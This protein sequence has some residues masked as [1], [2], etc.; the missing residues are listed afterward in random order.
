MIR[1]R[2]RGYVTARGEC[3]LTRAGF[4]LSVKACEDRG[5]TELVKEEYAGIHRKVCN[6]NNRIPGNLGKY[7]LVVLS[8]HAS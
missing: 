6:V 1:K 5:C 2:D 4:K 3:P 7:P 8:S